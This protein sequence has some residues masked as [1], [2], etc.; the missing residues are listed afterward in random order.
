MVCEGEIMGGSFGCDCRGGF[1][2]H[3]EASERPSARGQASRGGTC[4]KMTKAKVS[5][6]PLRDGHE[7]AKG[8]E[9]DNANF[10]GEEHLRQREMRRNKVGLNHRNRH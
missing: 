2:V 8:S 3:E 5:S 9:S 4:I 7:Q 10:I 1:V 6:M